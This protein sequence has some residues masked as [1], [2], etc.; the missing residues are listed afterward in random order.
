MRLPVARSGARPSTSPDDCT[1]A[2]PSNHRPDRDGFTLLKSRPMAHSRTS[3]GTGPDLSDGASLPVVGAGA[4]VRI[5]HNLGVVRSVEHRGDHGI[6]SV[7]LLGGGS[8]HCVVRSGEEA[9]SGAEVRREQLL[10]EVKSCP[11]CDE[12]KTSCAPLFEVVQWFWDVEVFQC[13]RCGL[14]FK[15]EATTDEFQ[16][17]LYGPSYTHFAVSRP[18]P[19]S[20]YGMRSRVSRL[21]S[22][23]GRH[24]DFG[25]G[26]GHF[27]S[28]AIDAGWDSVGADPFLPDIPFDTILGQRL[29]RA[30]SHE[31]GREGP[32][33]VI[34]MWGTAEHMVRPMDDFLA[35]AGNLAPG[36]MLVFN[37]PDGSSIAARRHASHWFMATL[38]EHR[39][40]LTASSIRWIADRTG[41]GLSK[42]RNCG[43]PFPLGRAPPGPASQGI[44]PGAIDEVAR[45]AVRLSPDPAA[46]ANSQV[47]SMYQRI[48]RLIPRP[49][50]SGISGDIAR[51]V[52]DLTGIGDHLEAVLVR[53]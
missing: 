7:A 21:G 15:G 27:V 29:R 23:A 12:S 39:I 3:G 46:P 22:P 9:L 11:L 25:C 37:C 10:A 8:V 45:T 52:M 43:S 44:P 35:L 13:S 50:V 47:H 16:G 30:T 31:V 51:R 6:A 20:S 41:L 53:R 32:F 5:D 49:S 40:F 42:L 2:T 17:L 36:G 28:A 18:S 48:A 24:L 26:A 14:V 19:E 34:S 4:L 1:N 38:L 33:Q